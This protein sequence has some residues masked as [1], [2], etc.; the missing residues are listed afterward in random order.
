MAEPD[1]KT[2]LLVEDEAIIAM[3]ERRQLEREGYRVLHALSGEKALDI[4]RELADPID[5]ILMDIDLGGGMSGTEAATVILETRDVPVLFLSSHVEKEVV[6]TTE[7]ISSYGYVVKHSSFTVL[8]ASI[9][10]AFRLYEAQKAI[11]R[12]NMEIQAANEELRVSLGRLQEINAALALSEEKFAKAFHHNP[13]SIN[14]NRLSDGTYLDIN[15]GFTR[16]TGYT[17]EDV[18][19]RSS[20]PGDLGIWVHA[21]DRGRL[22]A[23]LRAKGACDGLKAEFRR[24]DGAI[25]TGI[26]T[27][28][29]I[30]IGGETCIIS[31]TQDVSEATA[32]ERELGKLGRSLAAMLEGASGGVAL[33]GPD[34]VLRAANPAFAAALG[35]ARDRVGSIRLGELIHPDQLEAVLGQLG[36]A[37]APGEPARANAGPARMRVRWSRADGSLW[38]AETR[39]SVVRDESGSAELLV[40]HLADCPEPRDD[41][42]RTA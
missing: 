33:V 27:A 39:A 9:K 35:I 31:M 4:A 2:I 18:I 10:M 41:G 12:K 25:L 40:L 5:L 24:K 17:R 11:A 34:G 21:E 14:I 16:I 6:E 30:E 23:E 37:A 8:S 28:R 3:A 32:V 20:L 15:D 7:R 26:M 19:G 13:D 22:V 38:A 42:D 1:R 36:P 29:V